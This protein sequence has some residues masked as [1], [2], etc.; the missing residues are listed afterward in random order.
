MMEITARKFKAEGPY[1]RDSAKQ[2]IY[3]LSGL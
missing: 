3:N 1:F 2:I